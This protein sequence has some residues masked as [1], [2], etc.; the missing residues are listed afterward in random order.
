PYG[1][2]TFLNATWGT[3]SGSAYAFIYLFQGERFDPVTGLFDC[4]NREESPT[5]GRWVELDALAFSG[6][7]INLYRLLSNEPIANTD[8]SGFESITKQVQTKDGVISGK[9]T[10]STDETYTPPGGKAEPAVKMGY[11]ADKG[12][13]AKNVRWIQFI[14]ATCAAIAT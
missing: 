11:Y 6:G 5:L 3:L 12:K 13:S 1:K 8:P 7:D 9:L 14:I 2:V 10:A 4:Q